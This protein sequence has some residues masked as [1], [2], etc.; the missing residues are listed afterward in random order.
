M[1]VFTDIQR[2]L[3]VLLPKY[4]ASAVAALLVYSGRKHTKKIM[5]NQMRPAQHI[6][7]IY[8]THWLLSLYNAC[9]KIETCGLKIMTDGR[10]PALMN[11]ET[12]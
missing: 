5:E 9:E 12:L 1:S 8:T 3:F 7:F 11:K 2:V 10:A 6:G 4:A